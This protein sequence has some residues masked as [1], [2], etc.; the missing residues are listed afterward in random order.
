MHRLWGQ[1]P[2]I[3]ARPKMPKAPLIL[4][5]VSQ[6]VRK[7]NLPYVMNC[8]KILENIIKNRDTELTSD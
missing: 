8:E 2:I 3:A 4:Y 6:L 1:I 5:A 7:V